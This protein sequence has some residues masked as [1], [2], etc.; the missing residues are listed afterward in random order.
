MMPPAAR[1]GASSSALRTALWRHFCSKRKDYDFDAFDYIHPMSEPH[2]RAYLMGL[3]S[4]VGQKP[5][6]PGRCA[7][8]PRHSL[9]VTI[10]IVALTS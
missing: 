7:A 4:L 2:A 3:D 1:A 10:G 6:P 5:V 8:I 9:N